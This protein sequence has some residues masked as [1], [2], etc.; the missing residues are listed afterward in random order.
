MSISDNYVPIR[1]LGNGVTTQFS[2]SWAML[3]A[4]YARVYLESVS[5]GVQ[6]LQTSPTNYSIS[7]TSSGFTV[8][9]VTAPTS[10]N[11][12]VI[13]RDVA[14]DQSDPYRT[15]KGFQGA[16]IEDSFDKLTAIAQDSADAI[17]RSLKFQLGSTAV[18]VLPAPEDGKALI[19][20]GTAGA[21]ANGPT[22]TDISNAAA[23]AASAAA[24]ASTAT[25]AASQ[26][27]AAVTRWAYVNN[28]NMADPSSGNIRFNNSTPNLSTAIA[29]SANA[30][31]SGSP[32]YRAEIA[33]WDDSTGAIKGTLTFKKL[34]APENFLT[35]NVTGS[36]TDNTSW[37]QLTIAN[38]SSGGSI[39]NGDALIVEFVRAG[40]SGSAFSSSDITGQSSA[41]I[42]TG[43]S[44]VFS[45]VSNAGALRK[46]TIA[47][48]LAL[49]PAGATS[50]TANS[51]LAGNGTSAVNLIAPGTSGNVLTS[52]GTVWAS[53]TPTSGVTQG[54]VVQMTGSSVVM[55]V[56]FTT[57]SAYALHF[58][59]FTVSANSRATID[60]STD[61][62]GSYAAA[63]RGTKSFGASSFTS[64]TDGE[65][66]V[67]LCSGGANVEAVVTIAQRSTTSGAGC[68]I[69][70]G[71]SVGAALGGTSY[72]TSAAIN[73]IKIESPAGGFGGYCIVTPVSKR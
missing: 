3:N 59:D 11:Y 2:A 73:R 50:F 69:S 68:I 15:S 28:V 16:T 67:S 72:G 8:T 49:M 22:T 27:T 56:D 37:L 25:T 10:A 71:S 41:A 38:V 20:S 51:L 14:I 47:G 26:A 62:G 1:Q 33:T 35:F 18:G 58:I 57:Y 42:A 46:D 45:D 6:T 63:T 17:G 34:T 44:I 65:F 52:N 30:A 19:W 60:V 5:T 54:T 13:G 43:D 31:N 39:S 64:V 29:I 48:I 66:T 9:F 21:V 61:G 23:N 55:T 7:I 12:V 70:A 32:N 36:L 53:S 4:S 24:S 40:N